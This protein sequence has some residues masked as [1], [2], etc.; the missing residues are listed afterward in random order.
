MMNLALQEIALKLNELKQLNFEDINKKIS[1]N[2]LQEKLKN[3]GISN[4]TETS[5]QEVAKDTLKEKIKEQVPDANDANINK[6]KGNISE[7]L[8][9]WYFQNTGWEKLEGEVGCNGIDG[10]Y[11]KRD[12]DGNI[13]QILICESK[14]NTS[15][16]GETNNGTQMSKE[17]IQAK[18][19][20][21]QKANPDNKDYAAIKEM[22]NEDKYRARIFRL[23]EIDG[24]LKIEIAKV[25]SNGSE[26]AVTELNGK[27]NYKINKIPSIDL[28]NPDGKFQSKVADAYEN[29]ADQQIQIAKGK[30]ENKTNAAA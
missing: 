30:Y 7:K 6:I 15:Q 3:S 27:E 29:I 8:M 20:A 5:Q 12:K 2:D 9:D 17:W 23:K 11:V 19:D 28:Q 13:K 24:E 14:Y 4:V 10:L 18:L 26:V 22:V 25:D 1:P 16:L 21:L